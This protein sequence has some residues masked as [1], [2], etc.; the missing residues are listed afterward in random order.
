VIKVTPPVAPAPQPSALPAQKVEVTQD[1]FDLFSLQSDGK[2][3]LNDNGWAAFECQCVLLIFFFVCLNSV[4]YLGCTQ[5]TCVL[6]NK[7]K[8][9][10][11]KSRFKQL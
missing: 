2:A 8:L 11:L 9:P 6:C 1:L 4:G 3:A 7:G 10:I 5:G